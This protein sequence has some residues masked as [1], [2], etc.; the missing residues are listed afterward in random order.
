MEEEKSEKI[1]G[2]YD[3]GDIVVS[4]DIKFK[5]GSYVV[6]DS[7]A[8]TVGFSPNFIFKQREDFS[9]LRA[10]LDCTGSDSNGWCMVEACKGH[11][12]RYATPEEAAHYE[13]LKKPYD[14]TKPQVV[15]CKTQKQWD[16]V[17]SK[18]NPKNQESSDWERYRDSTY[19]CIYHGKNFSLSGAY[20]HVGGFFTDIGAKVFSF[21]E[22]CKMNGHAVPEPD[23]LPEKWCIKVTS[24][25]QETLGNWRT[26]GPL[27]NSCQQDLYLHTPMMGKKGYCQREI[28][29]GFKEITFEQ[30]KKW[31]LKE[32]QQVVFGL[33]PNH[34]FCQRAAE[35][36]AAVSSKAH[37]DYSNVA[38]ETVYSCGEGFGF[39]EREER[40]NQP[41]MEITLPGPHKVPPVLKTP[42]VQTEE[43][44]VTI[45]EPILGQKRTDEIKITIQQLNIKL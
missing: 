42:T 6:L 32:E 44:S 45:P 40:T 38:T 39:T 7:S 10:E 37:S 11:N 33:F 5:K 35:G 17:L 25:N 2:T 16:F 15:R 43:N 14:V 19:L 8:K 4:Q 1:L 31:V 22:W 20:G 41:A 27:V 3:I 23:E 18:F 24:Q 28:E 36:Y 29:P 12:W 21:G 30:F 34:G 9:Y 26:D 13:K